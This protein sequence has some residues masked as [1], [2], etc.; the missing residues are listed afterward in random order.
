MAEPNKLTRRAFLSSSALGAG[1]LAL[2]GCGARTG[3]GK[4]SGS[5]LPKISLQIAKDRGPQKRNM[6]GF[7]APRIE[8]VRIG[9]VGLG[10]RGGGA[11]NRLSK[12][13]GAMIV[14]IC[15]LTPDRVE[16]AKKRLEGLGVENVAGY[17][18]DDFAW[19]K[20]CERD[21]ID[22]VYSC[23][24]WRWH[25]PVSVYAMKHGKHAATE[26]PAAVTIDECWELVT[27]SEETGK[28][29]MQ[30]EN[31]CYDFFEMM[32]LNMARKGFLGDIIHAEGAY[33][34]NLQGNLT[35]KNG[36]QGMWRLI[37]NLKR[38]GNLYPT[39][40]L[41]PIAQCMNINRTDRFDYLTSV[42]SDDFQLGDLVIE[43]FGKD[44][45]FGKQAD[46]MRGN[47]STTMI[48]T[49]MGRSLMVQ[50]DVTTPRAYSRIHMV[51]G[52]KATVCKW[53]VEQ[54]IVGHK[55]AS[56]EKLK[57]ITEKYAHPLCKKIGEM[58]RKVGGHGGMDFMM[59][60]RLIQ[61]LREGEALDQDVYDAA[62]WSAVGPLSE[63]SVANRS[64][65]IDVP[66][67]T[68]SKWKTNK[69]LGIVS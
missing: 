61:C 60:F 32:T 39:H 31:C 55:V 28:H 65:S 18:G 54:I 36:Y 64:N 57:E 67:F 8:T 20:L 59:D 33:I 50:H 47:M 1:A 53:P 56:G 66:D 62:A 26:V 12:V 44:S 63:W 4:L 30:L 68:R 46:N 35:N 45:E 48:K 51:N 42:S 41:G 13:P 29:C 27:T 58:A 9:V 17:S 21:D 2:P 24:P 37:Q 40:G 6:C 43:K 14:A 5:K 38:N 15:D 7:K 19:K 22:L 3:E 23:T 11:L 69:P 52:A 25:T 16:R 49:S 10:S 34:H